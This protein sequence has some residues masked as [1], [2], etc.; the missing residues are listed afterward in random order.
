MGPIMVPMAVGTPIAMA[1]FWSFDSPPGEPPPPPSSALTLMVDVGPTTVTSLFVGVTE[2]RTRVRSTRPDSSRSSRPEMP[3]IARDSLA[4]RY[5]STWVKLMR[6]CPTDYVFGLAT[7]VCA[8]GILRP[9]SRKTR[10]SAS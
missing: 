4:T 10:S 5:E 6:N 1:I 2:T 9:S 7:L 3:S 8:S